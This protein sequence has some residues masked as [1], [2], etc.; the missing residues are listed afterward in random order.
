VTV[1]LCGRYLDDAEGN[2]VLNAANS[3]VISMSK[4]VI[5]CQG[6]VT[7][8]TRLCNVNADTRGVTMRGVGGVAE[9][10]DAQILSWHC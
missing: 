7:V 3:E 1:L 4:C 2:I 6:M 5:L 9:V 10:F 8:E